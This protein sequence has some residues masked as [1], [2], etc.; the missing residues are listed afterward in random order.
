[1]VS[2]ETRTEIEEQLGQVPSWIEVIPEPAGDHSW[3]LVRDLL[4][5][6]T[7]LAPREKALVGVGVAAAIKCPYCT[8]FHKEEARMAEVTEDELA[9]A[10]TLAGNTTYFSTVLHGSETDIEEFVD[11]TGE[12]VDYLREQE[13]AAAGAD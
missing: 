6:E 7:D 9:E 3:G 4:F 12:I 13:T 2:S 8:H 5:G 11:E 10:V 1:M